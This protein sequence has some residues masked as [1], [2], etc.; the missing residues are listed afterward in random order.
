VAENVADGVGVDQVS[1]ITFNLK[2]KQVTNFVYGGPHANEDIVSFEELMAGLT[3]WVVRELKPAL[4]P[5][6]HPD[7]RESEAIQ[8]HRIEVNAGDIIVVPLRYRNKT[9]GTMTA[10]NRP[11]QRRL[12]LEDVDLMMVMGSQ[13]AIAIENAQLYEQARQNA[14]V[15]ER[16]LKEVNHRVKNNLAAIA[17][18]LYIE[19]RHAQQSQIERTYPELI[20][21]LTRRIEGLATVHRLLSA[22]Q[23]SPVQL[24]EL[25]EQILNSTLQTLPAGK[26]V[27]TDLSACSPAVK[28]T[29]KQANNLAMVINELV[30]N[31]IKY[32]LSERQ[33]GR[34]TVGVGQDNGIILMEVRDNG[35]GFP[36]DVLRFERQNVG[37]YLVRNLIQGDLRGEIELQNDDG[38]VVMIRFPTTVE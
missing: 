12:T 19:R 20:Q 5:Y 22:S 7:P 6:D 28:V 9:I 32:V 3:G 15:N 16:L 21:D 11:Q 17:G 26:R 4:S 24:R 33:V 14:E 31:V 36:E 25:V 2:Q 37:L 18:M 13:A 38:G 30:T 35:S 34:I 27:I 1:I 10:V 8:R 29:P 23:W